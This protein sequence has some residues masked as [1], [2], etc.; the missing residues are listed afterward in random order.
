MELK[1]TYYILELGL[2]RLSPFLFSML[3]E[4]FGQLSVRVI[5]Y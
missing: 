3:D 4:I 1:K 5:Y 2:G